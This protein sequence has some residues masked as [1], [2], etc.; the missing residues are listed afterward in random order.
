MVEVRKKDKETSAALAR[1]FSKKVQYSGVLL[2]AR[3]HQYQARPLSKTQKKR[4]A[5]AREKKRKHY[6]KLRKLGKIK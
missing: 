1:R 4:N 2:T 5:L 3:A 6:E